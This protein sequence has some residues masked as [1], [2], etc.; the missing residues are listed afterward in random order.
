MY[1]RLFEG[2]TIFKF[3]LD[4]MLDVKNVELFLIIVISL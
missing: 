1:K 3:L 4:I 2:K